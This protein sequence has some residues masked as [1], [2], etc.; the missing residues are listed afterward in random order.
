MG[1]LRV[2]SPTGRGEMIG[3]MKIAAP[4]IRLGR[5]GDLAAINEIYN[6][7]V[8]TSHVTFDVEDRSLAWRRRWFDEHSRERH[9]V[10]VAQ[11]DGRVVGF[12]S[13]GTHRPR[14]AYDTSVETSVYVAAD[15][16]GSGIGG[17][18]YG[19]L[20]ERLEGCDVHRALAGITMPNPASVALHRAFGFRLVGRFTEQGR[21]FGR[22]WDVAWFERPM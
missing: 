21:K 5:V 13:S 22:Y 15:H 1:Y 2:T 3:G 9:L 17:S 11:R 6:H 16:T 18:L 7:Y 19:A 10:V 4:D 8:R 12:A 20:F 14:S